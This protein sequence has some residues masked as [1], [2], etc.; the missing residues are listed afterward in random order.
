MASFPSASFFPSLRAFGKHCFHG[1]LGL[2]VDGGCKRSLVLITYDKFLHTESRR[3]R[4]N[5]LHK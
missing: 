5:Q 2:L 1:L 4:I 3:R